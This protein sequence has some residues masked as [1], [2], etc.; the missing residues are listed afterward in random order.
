MSKRARITLNLDSQEEI[1]ETSTVTRGVKTPSGPA[2]EAEP[3]R[4][5]RAKARP[6]PK[7][8]P[9][10]QPPNG[11]RVKPQPQRSMNADADSD[12]AASRSTAAAESVTSSA[13][14]PPGEGAPTRG[15]SPRQVPAGFS[16]GTLLKVAGVG[17]VVISVVFWLKRK[18]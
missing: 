15:P 17:L 11:P 14:I 5:A 2:A 16:L 8:A 13:K 7:V 10:S 6:K 18:P 4:K 12:T 9:K 3:K 1:E